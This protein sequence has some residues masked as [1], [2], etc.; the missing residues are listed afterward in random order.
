M[1]EPAVECAHAAVEPSGNPD[2]TME[3]AHATVE[4]AYTAVE[5]AHAAMES[6][7]REPVGPD[8]LNERRSVCC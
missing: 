6:A 1:R 4:C 3:P 2:H 8:G 5:S 7:A